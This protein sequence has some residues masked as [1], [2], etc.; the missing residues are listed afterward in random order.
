M[1]RVL[2]L[3]ESLCKLLIIDYFFLIPYKIF[4]SRSHFPIERVSRRS[5][6]RAW[7]NARFAHNF[8]RFRLR[9]NE[10]TKKRNVVANIEGVSS[11]T[12]YLLFVPVFS[13]RLA[14]YAVF[15]GHAGARAS[16][17]AAENLHR[18]WASTLPAGKLI[19]NF[20]FINFYWN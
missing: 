16:R 20:I 19:C 14:Y 12:F 18:N 10:F 6:R 11:L 15:D 13:R 3:S 2:G 9:P 7:G 1:I 8:G 17:F 4:C 5:E